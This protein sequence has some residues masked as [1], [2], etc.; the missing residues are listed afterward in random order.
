MISYRRKMF[1]LPNAQSFACNLPMLA[2]VLLLG[3]L[4]A[5]HNRPLLHCAAVAALGFVGYAVSRMSRQPIGFTVFAVVYVAA[6]MCFYW[7][8]AWS[9]ALG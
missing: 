5:P 4:C 6:W 3:A 7:Q 1:R 9:G 8:S 2:V